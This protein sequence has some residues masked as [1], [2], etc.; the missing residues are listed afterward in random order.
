MQVE[1]QEIMGI[2]LVVIDGELDRATSEALA[3]ALSEE[4]AGR[5]GPRRAWLLDLSELTF[6]DSTLIARTYDLLSRLPEGGWV[7]V[8]G[9]SAGVLR[10]L[11]VGGLLGRPD[12]R[13]FS[14]HE[15][16]RVALGAETGDWG[17]T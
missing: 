5:D 13:V 16:A 8:I 6:T 15:E 10:V 3:L 12:V 2:P 14:N 9:A 1:R 17:E 11:T 4:E 7:G